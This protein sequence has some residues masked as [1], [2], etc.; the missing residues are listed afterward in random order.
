MNRDGKIIE[1]LSQLT[2]QAIK[3]SSLSWH[4]LYRDQ[5]SVLITTDFSL[6]RV[7]NLIRMAESCGVKGGEIINFAYWKASMES[8]VQ[9][10]MLNLNSSWFLKKSVERVLNKHH[11]YPSMLK[12][13]HRKPF[14]FLQWTGKRRNL[15]YPSLLR[16]IPGMRRHLSATRR[17]YRWY[18]EDTAN[19]I[20]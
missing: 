8:C 12:F 11:N 7:F 14:S 18:H 6:T 19:E 2:V 15:P 4:R 3:E 20:Q 13:K 9:A 10:C 5:K 16:W 17:Q 1:F